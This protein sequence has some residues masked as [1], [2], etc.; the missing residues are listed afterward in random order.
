MFKILESW[1]G[2]KMAHFDPKEMPLYRMMYAFKW[3]DWGQN[4]ILWCNYFKN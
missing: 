4:K 2:R 3:L 1:D